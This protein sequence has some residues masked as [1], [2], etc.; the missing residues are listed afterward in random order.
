[1][2]GNISSGYMF[3]EMINVHSLCM[4][5]H[6]HKLQY[7]MFFISDQSIEIIVDLIKLSHYFMALSLLTIHDISL[8]YLWL[9]SYL[10]RLY[11]FQIYIEQAFCHFGYVSLRHVWSCIVSLVYKIYT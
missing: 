8:E 6:F 4:I 3:I 10:Q 5:L 7:M 1:M 2:I 11:I 9:L